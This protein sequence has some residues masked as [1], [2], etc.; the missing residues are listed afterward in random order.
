M[1]FFLTAQL[2]GL[3]FEV[4]A[5]HT[6]SR[7]LVKL[8]KDGGAELVDVTK[9]LLPAEEAL[10]HLSLMEIVHY[11]FNYIGVLTGKFSMLS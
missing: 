3:S 5:A 7:E 11:S 1:F 9:K 10:L 6:K 8:E 2:V 4:N